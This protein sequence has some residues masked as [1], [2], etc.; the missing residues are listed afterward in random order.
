M[1]RER[2]GANLR[3]NNAFV[4]IDFKIKILA[5]RRKEIVL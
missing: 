1:C 2:V 4:P 5:R 3:T